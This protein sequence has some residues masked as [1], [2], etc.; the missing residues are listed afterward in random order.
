M[1]E[2]AWVATAAVYASF[3]KSASGSRQV[4]SPQ[5]DNAERSGNDY[6]Q[7]LPCFNRKV[8]YWETSTASV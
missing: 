8:F 3:S 1:V 5:R 6:S 2:K 4:V 7:E